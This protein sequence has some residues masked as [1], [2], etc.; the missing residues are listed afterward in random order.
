MHSTEFTSGFFIVFNPGSGCQDKEQAQRDIEEVLREAGCK[1]EFI[2]VQGGDVPG[3]CR[4]AA[5]RAKQAGGAI[6]SVGGDGTLNAA[7]AAA[8][9]EGCTLGVIPQGTF[10]LF[11]RDHGIPLDATEAA[12]ALTQA[13]P[14]EVQV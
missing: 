2:P 4:D 3:T 10:N 11:A 6:V 14:Q 9:A 8:L 5:R 12:R 13:W 1:F 7:A